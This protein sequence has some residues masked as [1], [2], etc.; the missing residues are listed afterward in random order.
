MGEA[1]FTG[2]LRGVLRFYSV[3]DELED[4]SPSFRFE[5]GVENIPGAPVALF[6]NA[7]AATGAVSS[8]DLYWQFTRVVTLAAE[9][10]F[11]ELPSNFALPGNPFTGPNRMANWDRDDD[12]DDGSVREVGAVL[13][14]RVQ[15][16]DAR[17]REG[18]RFLSELGL[19]LPAGPE[20]P[21]HEQS[22]ATSAPLILEEL[23]ITSG[24]AK[25]L[26][27][28]VFA[29]IREASVGLPTTAIVF[30][31]RVLFTS[32]P[33]CK[34][35]RY[36][37]FD[38]DD[39]RKLHNASVEVQIEI[40][41]ALRTR[42]Y[43]TYGALADALPS[44]P[45]IACLRSHARSLAAAGAITLTTIVERRKGLV[46]RQSTFA[47][48]T[49]TERALERL[50]HLR[51]VRGATILGRIQIR[52]LLTAFFPTSEDL[53]FIRA[54]V[55]M[56]TGFNV[57]TVDALLPSGWYK[58]HPHRPETLV[59][60]YAQKARARGLK[61]STYSNRHKPFHA[62]D[63][64]NRALEW[65]KPLQNLASEWLLNDSHSPAA[66]R[67]HAQRWRARNVEGLHDHVWIY[68]DDE[69]FIRTTR[70]ARWARVQA[71]IEQ[72]GVR[73]ANG[74]FPEF[75]GRIIRR[76]WAS[77]AYEKSGYNLV[78]TKLLL[79]HSD[80]DSLLAYI[81]S[82]A[83]HDRIFRSWHSLQLG[84]LELA[85]EGQ[86]TP[87]ALADWLRSHGMP[88]P[89]AKNIE[90]GGTRS[91]AGMLCADPTAPDVGLEP[92]HVA[93]RVCQRQRCLLGCSQAYPTFETAEYLA[94]RIT[95]LRH[96]R[97]QSSVLA[98]SASDDPREL[99]MA[100]A[101]F[102]R[103]APAVQERTLS[104][105][106]ARRPIIGT[107]SQRAVRHLEGAVE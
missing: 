3:L 98:W 18:W 94:R 33:Q 46:E 9:L 92:K 12:L 95:E 78:V 51:A 99:E 39:F 85:V 30:D 28:E 86:M 43:V 40:L 27:G 90:A 79:G 31:D 23:G 77:F 102:A 104:S 19:A 80:F 15:D 6:L 57:A 59:E 50:V 26:I 70:E 5:G 21:R 76:A 82:K 66:A 8:R 34:L 45:S 25:L 48:S 41:E 1:T 49:S 105:A 88:D 101:I 107:I 65:T 4:Q 103:Y 60:I 32:T 87:K 100:E 36:V 63:L 17:L 14:R 42:E 56:R 16:I 73:D 47:V 91:R 67:Q 62:Y 64:I 44:R 38:L 68:L 53:E 61:Q 83:E 37:E 11:G 7:L 52:R 71:E 55:L 20:L 93:G 13:L 81:A 35:D 54:L 96:I 22:D 10:K 75:G 74:C 2:I 72:S 58:P 24:R 89:Q 29:Q 106:G 84:V 97:T 69:G